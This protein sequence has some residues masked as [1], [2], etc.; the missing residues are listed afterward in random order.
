MVE[1]TLLGI[2]GERD[3]HH[4]RRVGGKPLAGRFGQGGFGSRQSQHFTLWANLLPA[5]ALY[6]ELLDHAR[7]PGYF[8]NAHLQLA[9]YGLAD[10]LRG[11]G[12]S[13]QFVADGKAFEAADQG[14]GDELGFAGQLD[15][16]DPRKKFSKEAC[17]PIRYELS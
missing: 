7:H 4:Q 6:R 9:W 5:L 16:F 12:R 13:G 15:G 17:P 3:A 2:I 10:T 8:T 1:L 14:G 11:A